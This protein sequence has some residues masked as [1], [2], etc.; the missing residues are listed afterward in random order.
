ME[1]EPKELTMGISYNSEDRIAHTILVVPDG[2]I[3]AVRGRNSSFMK[4]WRVS[5]NRKVIVD[6]DGS[7]PEPI[8]VAVW[9]VYTHFGTRLDE[10]YFELIFLFYITQL[11]KAMELFLC[12]IPSGVALSCSKHLAIRVATFEEILHD[13]SK[14]REEFSLESVHAMN[15]ASGLEPRGEEKWT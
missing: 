12:K 1:K 7:K 8:E 3:V 13:M 2:R 5:V 15:I 6:Y 9:S 14:N 4:Q 11:D 10:K